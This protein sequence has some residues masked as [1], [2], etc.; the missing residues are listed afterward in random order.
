VLTK[1]LIMTDLTRFD[2]F[3]TFNALYCLQSVNSLSTKT[4]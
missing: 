3:N 4:I 1:A 2:L